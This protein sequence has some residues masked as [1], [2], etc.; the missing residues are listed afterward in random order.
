MTRVVK[1]QT[2]PIS[3]ATLKSVCSRGTCLLVFSRVFSCSQIYMCLRRRFS[4]EQ[5]SNAIL[6]LLIIILL[7]VVFQFNIPSDD[8]L[9]LKHAG[10][11]ILGSLFLVVVTA[12]QVLLACGPCF[13]YKC[14]SH[15][16]PGAISQV[17]LWIEKEIF[18]AG[19][20][21]ELCGNSSPHYIC[22]SCKLLSC[23]ACF[24]VHPLRV[25][26]PCPRCKNQKAPYG[27]AL[28]LF[29]S[30]YSPSPNSNI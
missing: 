25:I 8:Y 13:L 3:L 29:D 20:L 26:I 12:T 10:G 7:G 17:R 21:C 6:G 28:D 22:G 1:L 19:S 16:T 27:V 14:T 11:I 23:Y 2:L 9:G 30:E 4:F 5:Y 24:H 18:P 15:A